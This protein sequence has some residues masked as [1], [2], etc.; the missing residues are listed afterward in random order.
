MRVDIPP[1]CAGALLKT[2]KATIA[3][4]GIGDGKIRANATSWDHP[5]VIKADEVLEVVALGKTVHLFRRQRDRRYD[6]P[7]HHGL[8][9]AGYGPKT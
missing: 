4:E 5:L 1:F 8:A 6:E 3:L 2:E 9:E 7:E